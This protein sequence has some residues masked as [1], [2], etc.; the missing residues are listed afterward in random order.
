MAPPPCSVAACL[1]LVCHRPRLGL[2][3][4]WPRSQ[5]EDRRLMVMREPWCNRMARPRALASVGTEN[6]VAGY[7]VHFARRLLGVYRAFAQRPV[8][9]SITPSE[10]PVNASIT[11]SKRLVN[12]SITPSKRLVNAGI[13]PSK[14]LV[15][16]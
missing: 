15:N 14:R 12:A 2:T 16:A 3:A 10:R 7:T 9:A 5:D 8:N 11:P 13:T 1:C 6:A 4:S